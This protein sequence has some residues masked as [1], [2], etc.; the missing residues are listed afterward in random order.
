MIIKLYKNVA[1]KNRVNKQ[2]YLTP[3]YEF[4]GY[5]REYTDVLSPNILIDLSSTKKIVDDNLSHVTY[6][7]KNKKII[8]GFYTPGLFK[9]NYA[10]IPELERYYFVKNIVI[11][12]LGLFKINL[13]IDVLYTYKNDIK[14][15]G[16]I[17]ARNEF[18][19]NDYIYDNRRIVENRAVE[20]HSLFNI[21]SGRGFNQDTS[22]YRYVLT[23]YSRDTGIETLGIRKSFKSNTKY[24]LNSVELNNFLTSIN[25][26]NFVEGVKNIFANNPLESIISIKAYPLDLKNLFNLSN[27]DRK[28]ILLGSFSTGITAYECSNQ[29]DGMGNALA[30]FYYFRNSVDFLSFEEN[31]Q[32]Y[33]PF[34]GFVNID[35]SAIIGRRLYVWYNVDFDNGESTIVLYSTLSTNPT[36][37]DI[38]ARYTCSLSV[39]IPISRSN[40]Y[41]ISQNILKN[42]VGA[43]LNLAVGNYKGILD[44]ANKLL[45]TKVSI[46][47]GTGSGGGAY[48]FLYDTL[49]PLN[50][51]VHKKKVNVDL[52]EYAKLNGFPLYEYRE[53]NNLTGY[54]E[55]E[56]IH[57]E[58]MANATLSEIE[59]IESLLK[60]GIIL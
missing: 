18:D 31:N 15:L 5:F 34:Y 35:N 58:N 4:D 16:G 10:Y 53:L 55:I 14:N 60:S 13:E 1:E 19:Y 6:G 27:S 21:V 50:I 42:V 23:C 51:S 22:V 24:L 57:I 3:V 43:G 47:R 38:I 9:C 8:Y 17:I 29:C 40:A 32:I 46:E 45:D 39:D 48:G 11:M 36:E 41:E 33:L 59:L 28:E 52:D 26:P 44:N 12:G 20:F 25:T 37:N 54:T 49:I 7:K 2:T 56:S 30:Q